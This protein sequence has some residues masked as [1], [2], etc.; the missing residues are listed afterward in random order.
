MDQERR[1]LAGSADA[2]FLELCARRGPGGVVRVSDIVEL[3]AG[4]SQEQAGIWVSM[5]V[6]SGDLSE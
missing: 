3:N 1:H 2:L 4:I 5:I 6:Y